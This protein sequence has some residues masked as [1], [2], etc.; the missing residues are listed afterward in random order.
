MSKLSRL[1]RISFR[2]NSLIFK[3]SSIFLFSF[4]IILSA[5]AH[6]GGLNKDGCHNDKKNNDYHCHKDKKVEKPKKKLPK[7]STKDYVT[8]ENCYDGDTCTSNTGEKIRLACI[9]TPEIRGPRANPEPAKAARD[10]LNSQ[11]AGKEVLIRRITKDR[12]E[13][14]VGELSKNGTN[15]QKLMVA[16]GYAKIYEKYAD[17]CP[18][19]SNFKGDTSSDLNN[20]SL[21]DEKKDLYCPNYLI[22]NGKKICL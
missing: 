5:E 6:N 14:T 18:W 22:A 7:V 1:I 17:P 3:L 4:I 16:K 9:D 13:R 2:S 15:I 10:F 12:Y 19:A 21:K 20:L 8:I 11:V